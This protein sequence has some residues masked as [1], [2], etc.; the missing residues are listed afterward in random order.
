[1]TG[2][3]VIAFML[4]QGKFRLNIRENFL[5]ERMV[6]NWNRLLRERESLEVFKGCVVVALKGVVS[7]CGGG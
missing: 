2:Q 5:S 4:R 1:M 3:E 7:W 6:M